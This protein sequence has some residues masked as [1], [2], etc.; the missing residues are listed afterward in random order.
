MLL[1]MEETPN[2]FLFEPNRNRLLKEL[3]PDECMIIGPKN[4]KKISQ[5]TKPEL[6]KTAAGSN[7]MFGELILLLLQALEFADNFINVYNQF[8]KE[9]KKPVVQNVINITIN[10]YH[11]DSFRLDEDKIKEIAQFCTK[12]I[13]ADD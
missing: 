6:V 9:K 4:L 1:I 8:K 10:N 12:L 11:I 7:M 2:I 5:E 13:D 3:F